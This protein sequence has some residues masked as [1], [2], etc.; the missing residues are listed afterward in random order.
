MPS[1]VSQPT[2]TRWRRV[3]AKSDGE[4]V[5]AS[6]TAE[7]ESKK[8]RRVS[9]F[10]AK[11]LSPM[12]PEPRQWQSFPKAYPAFSASQSLKPSPLGRNL[13][14]ENLADSS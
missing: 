8:L 4:A 7:A 2:K 5:A 3:D 6:V 11:R 12:G 1:D 14:R 10:M 9:F 13:T